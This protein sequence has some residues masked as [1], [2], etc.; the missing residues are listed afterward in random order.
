MIDTEARVRATFEAVAAATALHP[1]YVEVPRR[2]HRLVPVLVAAA[3]AFAFA[4]VVPE[5]PVEEVEAPAVEP[6][7]RRPLA[8]GTVGN[9]RWTLHG[10]DHE[11]RPCVALEV[12]GRGTASGCPTERP[13]APPNTIWFEQLTPDG[14]GEALALLGVSSDNVERVLVAVDDGPATEAKVVADPARPG[15][16]YVV[17]VFASP[18]RAMRLTIRAL[19]GEGTVLESNVQDLRP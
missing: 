10:V 12:E 1:R 15:V 2:R 18:H 5:R 3:A 17:T 7:G 9:R 11:G 19:G 4:A 6:D 13:D 14:E 16:R 8:E